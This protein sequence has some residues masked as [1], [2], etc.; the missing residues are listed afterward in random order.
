MKICPE[1]RRIYDE[2]IYSRCPNCGGELMDKESYFS[3]IELLFFDK[4][5]GKNRYVSK[6]EYEADPDRYEDV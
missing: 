3:G 6:D 2:S 4:K 5:K 1:C